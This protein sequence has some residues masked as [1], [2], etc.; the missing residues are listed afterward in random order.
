M[1]RV[2]TYSSIAVSIALA[3]GL[4]AAQVGYDDTPFLPDGPDASEGGPWRVHDSRRPTPSV[5]TPG[6]TPGAPPSDA[7][8]L[9]DGTS[10]DGWRSTQ[11]GP[12]KWRVVD[13]A[14][15]VNGTGSIETTRAFGDCQLHVEWAAP[16]EVVG[17]SQG[18]GNSGVF[19][20]ERYEVQVLDSFDNVT[21]ADGQA[22]AMYGQRPP[23]VNASRAPG[24]W[25]SYDIVFRRPHFADDGTVD[26][27][28]RITVFH[29]G[30]VV[31][32]AE[33]FVGATT[34][35]KLARYVPHADELPLQL[36][37]HGNPIRYRNIWIRQLD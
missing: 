37:D 22:A 28:A 25:Q 24:E 6:S 21:Y 35:K 23:L 20:M 9:F 30:V 2:S 1:T 15:E 10:L 27:P 36:Q 7:V 16:A 33:P 4:A 29:N 5:V 34:H 32:D 26:V 3:A 11:D 8:V 18:R 31:H 13:G 12:A 17:E 19:L 14:M